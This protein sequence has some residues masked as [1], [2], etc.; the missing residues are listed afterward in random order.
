MCEIWHNY[1]NAYNILKNGKWRA[2]I[3][4]HQA[5]F[6]CNASTQGSE[7]QEELHTHRVL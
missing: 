3:F 6:Q 2:L 1:N 4:H 5:V 7:G